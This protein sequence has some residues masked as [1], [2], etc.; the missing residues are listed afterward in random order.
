M[1]ASSFGCTVSW[2]GN[3]NSEIRSVDYSG[4]GISTID[5]THLSSSTRTMKAGIDEARTCTVV[6]TDGSTWSASATAGALIVS[7]FGTGSLGN[8]LLTDIQTSIGMDA[9]VEHT[10]TFTEGS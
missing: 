5:A 3:L 1:A 2:G 9:A 7:T 8:F 10:Y 4:S 6:T